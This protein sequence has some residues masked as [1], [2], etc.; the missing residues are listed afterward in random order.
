MISNVLLARP[1]LSPT[2][3]GVLIDLGPFVGLM[4]NLVLFVRPALFGLSVV[5]EALQ[6]L[7]PG[8]G[9]SCDT[10]DWLSNT[11]GAATGAAHAA[12][13]LALA[14]VDRCRRPTLWCLIARSQ[15]RRA[16]PAQLAEQRPGLARPKRRPAAAQPLSA[17]DA[18]AV[19]ADLVPHVGQL[20][21]RSTRARPHRQGSV[22]RVR[23]RDAPGAPHA[24]RS[25]LLRQRTLGMPAARRNGDDSAS[26]QRAAARGTCSRYSPPA[27]PLARSQA[28]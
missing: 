7:V 26:H 24:R 12:A 2:A 20:A 5:L 22:G 14:H 19:A 17:V 8:L 11:I 1:W 15:H 6:A 10:T 25:T 18:A 28:S 13:A 3:L 21:A 9:R 23:P 27:A 4:A 16:G